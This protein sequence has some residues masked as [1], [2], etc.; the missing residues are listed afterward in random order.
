MENLPRALQRKRSR[1][2]ETTRRS[3]RQRRATRTYRLELLSAVIAAWRDRYD[4]CGSRSEGQQTRPLRSRTTSSAGF[5][6]MRIGP[7]RDFMCRLKLSGERAVYVKGPITPTP[8]W[9]FWEKHCKKNVRPHFTLVARVLLVNKRTF[10]IFL[11][12]GDMDAPYRLG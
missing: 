8:K 2:R 7:S 10:F 5:V 6:D 11:G 4:V 12:A 9:S 1:A 3:W